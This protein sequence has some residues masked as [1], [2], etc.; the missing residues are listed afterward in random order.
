VRT[1]IAVQ[2]RLMKMVAPLVADED[3]LLPFV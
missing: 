2:S 3:P 1:H